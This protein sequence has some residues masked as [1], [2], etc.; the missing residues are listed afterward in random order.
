MRTSDAQSYALRCLPG[1]E[2]NPEK[3]P[4]SGGDTMMDTGIYVVANKYKQHY[5]N[6]VH[7]AVIRCRSS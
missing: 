6:P 1:P 3:L 4:E 7:T 5:K 2:T